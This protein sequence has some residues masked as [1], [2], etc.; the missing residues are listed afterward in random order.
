MEKHD[1][2]TE[3]RHRRSEPDGCCSLSLLNVCGEVKC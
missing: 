3:E 2:L 1:L